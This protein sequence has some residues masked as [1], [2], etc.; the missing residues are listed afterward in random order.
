LA[1]VAKVTGCDHYKLGRVYTKILKQLKI[2]LEDIDPSSFIERIVS[3]LNIEDKTLKE[4]LKHQALKLVNI[5]KDDWLVTGR[6]PSAVTAAAVLVATEMKGI[7]VD[8]KTIAK[9]LGISANTIRLR[10]R[11]LVST[12]VKLGQQLPWG[13]SI[14]EKNVVSNID[15]IL[16]LMEF[17]N[18][19]QQNQE[20]KGSAEK[21]LKRKL[22]EDNSL[23][24]QEETKCRRT[25]IEDKC[26]PNIGQ[27]FP[28]SSNGNCFD[29]KVSPIQC[30]CEPESSQP[31]SFRANETQREERRKRIERAKKRL[32][33]LTKWPSEKRTLFLFPPANII[34]VNETHTS[35][36]SSHSVVNKFQNVIIKEE[37]GSKEIIGDEECDDM[38]DEEDLQIERLLL[39]KVDENQ[40]LDG[41]YEFLL[42]KTNDSLLNE[43][44]LDSVEL[45]ERDLPDKELSQFI[46]T[47]EEVE[48][49]EQL[50]QEESHTDNC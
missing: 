42:Q 24:R 38:C 1:E 46:R 31:P 18:A 36:Q 40:L 21:P 35:E 16:R 3:G 32:E 26:T 14:D 44:Y 9:T 11:E 49:F 27:G 10:Q 30:P 25:E 2:N 47:K 4:V 50:N 48:F 17:V 29:E 22:E 41:H 13:S 23:R 28:K 7:D 15:E 33:R 6:K 19:R 39:E 8:F 43:K 37:K 34:N 5:A 45:T 12:L 20:Q